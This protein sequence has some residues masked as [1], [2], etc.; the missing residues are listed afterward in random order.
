MLQKEILII[1][2]ER[3]DGVFRSAYASKILRL[4]KNYRIKI[5]TEKKKNSLSN[6]VYKK[7]GLNNFIYISNQNKNYKNLYL[8]LISFFHSIFLLLKILSSTQYTLSKFHYNGIKIG[9]L[10]VDH[11]ARYSPYFFNKSYLNLYTFKVIYHT[12]FKILF[13]K[14]YIK[15]NNIK[16]VITTS[17]S[18]ASISS[19]AIRVALFFDFSVVLM[20]PQSEAEYSTITGEDSAFAI[21]CNAFFSFS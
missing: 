20:S 10:L 8:I 14:R 1:D 9:D 6:N 17:Y 19:I 3:L 2:R 21:L 11:I 4:K 13:I 5:L 12:L 7:L 16:L 18:Y 15:N